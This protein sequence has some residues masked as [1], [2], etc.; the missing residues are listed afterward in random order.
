MKNYESPTIESAGSG[1]VEGT[2][3]SVWSAVYADEITVK[4]SLITFGMFTYLAPFF[5]FRKY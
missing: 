3:L 4:I 5:L 2:Y 1:S